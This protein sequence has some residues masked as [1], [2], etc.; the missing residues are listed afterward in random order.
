MT[1]PSIFSDV[2]AARDAK[3]DRSG[4]VRSQKAV[5][6]IP[7]STAADTIVGMIRFDEGFSLDQLAIVSADLDTAT[8]VTLDV[9]F[10]YDSASLTDNE[11]AFFDGIDIVQDAGSVVYPVADGLLTGTG[12]VAE[13]SGYIVVQTKG[14]S[15]T[16]EGDITVKALFSYD[17]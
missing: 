13:G 10:V 16:T 3:V 5:A 9:G 1:T 2:A 6:T 17:G 15:T 12:F 14:A 4:A 7:A 8:N 11:D